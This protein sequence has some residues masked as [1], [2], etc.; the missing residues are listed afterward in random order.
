MEAGTVPEK[1]TISHR[2]EKY[3]IGRGKRFYGIWAVG[4][5]YGAPVD[6]WPETRDGWEQAWARFV[7]LETPGTI[8]A[9]ERPSF[10]LP[11]LIG[12]RRAA[13]DAGQ[14]D[15]GQAEAAQAAARRLLHSPLV[16]ALLLVFGVVLGLIGLFPGYLGGQSLTASADQL[17]PHLLYLAVWAVSAALIARAA[18]TSRSARPGALLATGVS[19]ATLGLLLAD[20]G[21]AVSGGASSGAGLVL[22]LLGWLLCAAGAMVALVRGRQATVAPVVGAAVG[23]DSPV[24]RTPDRPGRL[25]RAHAGP[26]ALLLLAG[27]GTAITFAPSWDK[28]VLSV[29]GNATQTI[30]AGNAF[31]NPGMVIAGDVVVMALIVVLA[32]IAALWRP[33]R[34]GGILLAGAIVP[35]VAQAISA[36]I[37]VGQPANPAMFGISPSEASA[38]GLTIA[39]GVT[40][41]FW[42]Y[43]AF[44]ISLVIS[45]AW[46][47][48]A[49]RPAAMPGMPAVPWTP[50]PGG[51]FAEAG[52]ETPDSDSDVADSDDGVG[53]GEQSAYA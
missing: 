50:A 9:V 41:V 34:N 17:V 1:A 42:V 47:F 27:L 26:L 14:G 31:H 25:D 45:C 18:V 49:P 51:T 22:T 5:P 52:S 23:D 28:Y 10:T 46:L 2:G 40:P 21:E 32:A 29:P 7:A 3:E 38:A 4:A 6:R 43:C 24:A 15:A 36:L 37:Q 30:T 20:L 8:A 44:V 11:K 48:T 33:A 13:A 53:D 12:R 39:S 19:G 35:L 16:G